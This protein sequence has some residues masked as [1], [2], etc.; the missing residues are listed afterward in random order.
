M[1][2]AFGVNRHGYREFLE[3]AEGAREDKKSWS[4]FLRYLKE[5]GLRGIRMFTSHKCVGLIES[6]GEFYPEVLWQRCVVHYFRNV[7]TVVPEGKEGRS[8]KG[9]RKHGPSGPSVRVFWKCT[10]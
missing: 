10:P 5:R 2:V 7:F 9:P 1:L 3:V 4:L 6:L 8:Q